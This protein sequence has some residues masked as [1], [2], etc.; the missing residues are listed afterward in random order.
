MPDKTGA[1]QATAILESCDEFNIDDDQIVAVSCDNAKTNVGHI[2]GTCAILE[3]SLKKPLLRLMCNQHITEIMIKDVYH[4]LFSS[5]AP[6]NLFYPILRDE[7]MKLRERNFP[8]TPF[9]EDIFVESLFGSP[10]HEIF[11]E[12]KAK[13][14]VSM[15]TRLASPSIRDDYKELN[16]LG[17]IFL[18]ERFNSTKNNE[19]KFYALINPSNARF[20]GTAIQA[21]KTFLFRESLDFDSPARTKIRQNLQRFAIFIVLIYI[22]L[23]NGSNVLYDAAINTIDCLHNLERYSH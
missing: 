5:D 20:M 22:P 6:N 12:L 9:R 1:S 7:W 23:W 15:Q 13:A 4:I 10:D 2:S 8:Y 16:R 3:Q 18:S 14:L 19:V 17:M 11:D 21:M